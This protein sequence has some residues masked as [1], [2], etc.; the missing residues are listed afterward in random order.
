[1]KRRNFIAAASGGVSALMA[2]SGLSQEKK[3]QPKPAQRS[4]SGIVLKGITWGTSRGYCPLVATS[5]RFEETHPGVK[6]YWERENYDFAQGNLE[7]TAKVYDI[8]MIDHP[9]VGSAA[10][11]KFLVPLDDYLPAAY[12]KD[13]ADNSVGKSHISYSYN[14]K[15]WG[16]ATDAATPVAFYRPDLMEK[17]KAEI[18]KTWEDV[19]ELAKKKLAVFPCD[20]ISNLMNFFMFCSTLKGNMFPDDKT[21]VDEDTGVKALRYMRDLAVLMS[22]E[23]YKLGT[24]PTHEFLISQ[25]NVAYCPF[26]Y[27]YCN[28]SRRGY[29]RK[30]LVFADIVTL[31]NNGILHSTLGGAGLSVSATSQNRETAIEYIAYATSP[32]IQ[33]SLYFEAGGQPGHRKAWLDDTNN[34][35][36]NNFFKNTLKS[37]DNSYLRP[38]Y[39]KYLY[40]QGKGGVP[41]KE[42]LMKGGNEK[43]VL[44]A[45]T[46][47]YKESKA[48]EKKG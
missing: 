8:M 34:M 36:S 42:Y 14:G 29:G 32:E 33:S 43:D 39:H 17:F 28:Y 12:L 48:M 15:Q 47:L 19:I 18:P 41:I 46:D 45:I 24:S 25:D 11:R 26:T 7:E 10:T 27:P 44:N 16:L 31:G 38:T 35:L 6:I 30:V 4:S 21:V 22:D 3:E 9:H 40:F 20:P 37:H 5:K 2:S 23:I 13:Q 1:M